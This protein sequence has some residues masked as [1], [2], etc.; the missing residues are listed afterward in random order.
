MEGT[1]SIARA[2][3]ALRIVADRNGQGL[4]LTEVASAMAL[5]HPTVRRI[6]KA[7]VAEEM[8]V[9]DAASRRY[10]LG[11]ML[12]DL[13]LTAAP[14]ND[15]GALCQESLERLA[16]RTGDTVFLVKRRGP[17]AGGL[18]RRSGAFPVKAFVLDVGVRR[19]LGVGAGSLA[20]LAAMPVAEAETLLDRNARLFVPFGIGAADAIRTD[21]QRA[22]ERRGLV[23]RD[24]PQLGVRT[25]ALALHAATGE[26]F[27]ALS[28]SS[29][30]IR[31]A[32]EHHD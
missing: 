32:D 20:M 22:R 1:Q 6:L 11:P 10:F 26:A 28:V 4:G 24:I 2:A 16:A 7:L 14:R 12:A 30:A 15:I 27:A 9:Q 18:D 8:I 31:M 3:A 13:G 17:D 19:P 29:L 23:V 21:I 5:P 25:L